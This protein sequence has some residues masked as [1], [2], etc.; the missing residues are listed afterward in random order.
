MIVYEDDVTNLYHEWM[1]RYPI[2]DKK[3]KKL[4]KK[5]RKDANKSYMIITFLLGGFDELNKEYNN[6]AKQIIDKG[7]VDEIVHNDHIG[8]ET[9]KMDFVWW[10]LFGERKKNKGV[11]KN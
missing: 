1:S 4:I 10:I 3:L 8:Y 9:L 6:L 7:L 2:K 5:L 11:R